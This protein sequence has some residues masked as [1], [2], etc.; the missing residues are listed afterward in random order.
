MIA[1]ANL[2][3]DDSWRASSP[4]SGKCGNARRAYPASIVCC[5]AKTT[6]INRDSIFRIGD[7]TIAK[8]NQSRR[9]RYADIIEVPKRGAACTITDCP[10]ALHDVQ[11]IATGIHKKI[12]ISLKSMLQQHRN[13]GRITGHSRIE[14]KGYTIRGSRVAVYGRGNIWQGNARI[15]AL[16]H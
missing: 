1:D 5:D 10:G 3:R 2:S 4:Q 8:G 15:Y 6:A 11:G 9:T 14:H 13:T 7:S 16:P 12:E